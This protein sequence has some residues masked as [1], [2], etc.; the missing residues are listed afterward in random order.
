LR[1]CHSNL[2]RAMKPHVADVCLVPEVLT[3]VLSSVGFSINDQPTEFGSV[4]L[5][6]RRNWTRVERLRR[7]LP[8][9]FVLGRARCP[10]EAIQFLGQSK[11]YPTQAHRVDQLPTEHP[12]ARGEHAM[13]IKTDSASMKHQRRELRGYAK[14][15]ALLLAAEHRLIPGFITCTRRVWALS[16]FSSIPSPRIVLPGRMRTRLYLEG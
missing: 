12:L 7:L 3:D 6:K 11:S 15:A 9:Q 16:A 8:L 1:G 2:N 5:L 13:H 10:L 14:S 4:T